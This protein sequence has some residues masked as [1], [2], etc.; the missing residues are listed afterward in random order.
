MSYEIRG[1]PDPVKVPVALPHG[2][3]SATRTSFGPR[4][5]NAA[6]FQVCA[7][8]LAV[9][10]VPEVQTTRRMWSAPGYGPSTAEPGKSAPD[11]SAPHASPNEISSPAS[12]A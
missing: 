11:R 12:S 6:V 1:T 8:P 3:I 5:L 2:A 4:P 9:D 7:Q 10:S